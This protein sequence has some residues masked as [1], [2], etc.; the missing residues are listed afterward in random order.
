MCH[1]SRLPSHQ[2]SISEH[3]TKVTPALNSSWACSEAA[4]VGSQGAGYEQK[5][6][7]P[8]VRGHSGLGTEGGNGEGD[9]RLTA[10]VAG[11]EQATTSQSQI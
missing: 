4:T 5:G 9:G 7:G 3:L 6:P 11:V 2:V 8:A 10:E 1:G